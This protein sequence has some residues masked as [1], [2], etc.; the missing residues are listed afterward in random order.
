MDPDEAWVGHDAGDYA[1]EGEDE[2]PGYGHCDCVGGADVWVRGRD[3]V[4]G[5]V[6]VYLGGCAGEGVVELTGCDV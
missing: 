2:Q 6:V 4:V 5:V 3:V 1:A